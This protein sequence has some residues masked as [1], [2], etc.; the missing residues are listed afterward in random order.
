MTDRAALYRRLPLVDTDRWWMDLAAGSVDGRV[1]E[2]GAG[3]GRLTT[4]LLGTGADVTAVEHDP[5][6]LRALRAQVGVRARVLDADV[7]A[8]PS[9]LRA[10]VV[11]VATSLLNELPDLDSRRR[12]LRGAAHVCHPNGIVAL[13]L[14]GPW[15][16]VNLEGRA[17]GALTPADGGP[18]IEVT[19]NDEGFDAWQ[20]RR[21][22]RIVYR[23][24]DHATMA[25]DLDAAVVSPGELEALVEDAGLSV[26]AVYGSHPPQEPAAGDPAWHVVAAPAP[27]KGKR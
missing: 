19:I 4:A 15:W 26:D 23:F 5:S 21:R 9:G 17:T 7:T 13:H 3:T 16:L 25:D 2:L 27:A 11:V 10:G 14:L 24:P 8:L 6:M 20:S 1:V 22:A 12:L 18:D